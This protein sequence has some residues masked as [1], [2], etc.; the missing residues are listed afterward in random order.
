MGK[1]PP[2]LPESLCQLLLNSEGNLGA[3]ESDSGVVQD[4]TQTSWCLVTKGNIIALE[5]PHSLMVML[6]LI[7]VK[8]FVQFSF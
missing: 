3:E 7:W 6:F 4:A 8:V 1:Q 2:S 5:T